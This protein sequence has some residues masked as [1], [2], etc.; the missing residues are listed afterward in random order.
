MNLRLRSITDNCT[1]PLQ[2]FYITQTAYGHV[3]SCDLRNYKEGDK[4]IIE[5][6]GIKIRLTGKTEVDKPEFTVILPCN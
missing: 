2:R 3:E 5:P 4:F 1:V 6:Y